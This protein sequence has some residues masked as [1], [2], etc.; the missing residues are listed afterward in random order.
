MV[1]MVGVVVVAVEVLLVVVEAVAAGRE[2]QLVAGQSV[3]G[4]R[5]RRGSRCSLCL[6]FAAAVQCAVCSVQYCGCRY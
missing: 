3:R 2:R 1:V 5:Q 4:G 6:A